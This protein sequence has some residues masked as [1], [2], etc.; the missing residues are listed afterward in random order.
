M[1]SNESLA[2]TEISN[3][4][5]QIAEQQRLL[6]A[7]WAD[8]YAQGANKHS[9]NSAEIVLRNPLV[10]LQGLNPNQLPVD[11]EER[12]SNLLDFCE[13]VIKVA[14]TEDKDWSV[15]TT[16]LEKVQSLLVSG[17]MDKGYR[18]SVSDII[19]ISSELFAE[20]TLI[21]PGN[22]SYF[23]GNI[24][25]MSSWIDRHRKAVE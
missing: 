19:R 11:I 1:L 21:I 6:G 10:Y 22:T 24:R 3:D 23:A 9:F 5:Q 7:E 14:A 15:G 12:W 16:G 8:L 4:P 17:S 18:G 2:K 20:S 25:G 13:D